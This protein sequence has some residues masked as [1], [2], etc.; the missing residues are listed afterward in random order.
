MDDARYG[1]ASTAADVRSCPGNRARG[2]NAAENRRQTIGYALSDESSVRI[3]LV[4]ALR[5]GDD[6]RQEAFDG[7]QHCY[8]EGGLQYVEES[9]EAQ[10]WKRWPRQGARYAAK[11]ASNGF[12]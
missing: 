7:A 11:S 9:R 10:G 5:I 12:N 2:G 4:P 6:T 3:V 1:A 8:C